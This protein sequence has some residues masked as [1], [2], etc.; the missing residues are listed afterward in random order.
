MP[1]DAPAE[2]AFPDVEHEPDRAEHVRLRKFGRS[3]RDAIEMPLVVR[4]DRTMDRSA[5]R[6]QIELRR[7]ERAR[8]EAIRIALVD[9]EDEAH[10]VVGRPWPD[11]AGRTGNADRFRRP[12]W[13][14]IWRLR[15][16]PEPDAAPAALPVHVPLR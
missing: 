12:F 7:A 1:L 6:R 8:V 14:C 16:K 10:P 2:I 13:M 15:E 9:R 3:F 4:A 5:E 11:R